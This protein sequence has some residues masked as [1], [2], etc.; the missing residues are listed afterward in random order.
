M[1]SLTP[2][3]PDLMYWAAKLANKPLKKSCYDKKT[4]IWTSVQYSTMLFLTP[5][6]PNLPYW[7]SKLAKKQLKKRC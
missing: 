3:T 7:A 4:G 1:N 6:P 5:K 2:K